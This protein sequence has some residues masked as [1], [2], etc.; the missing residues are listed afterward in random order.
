[1]KVKSTTPWRF[2][3]QSGNLSFRRGIGSDS[4]KGRDTNSQVCWMLWGNDTNKSIWGPFKRIPDVRKFKVELNGHDELFG[5]HG[6]KKRNP[7]KF[8]FE[9]LGNSVLNRYMEHALSRMQN[10]DEKT[11]WRIAD[12]LVQRSNI[13]L[14][15]CLNHVFPN[16][17]RK[18]SM[19]YILAILRSVRKLCKERK[20]FA[21]ISRVYI[22]K[23]KG[24]WRPLGVPKAEWRLYLHMLN[25]I[26]V[27]RYDGIISNNQH[28]FRPGRGTLTAWR[29]ILKRLDAPTIYEYDYKG[30]FDSI[31]Y[32]EVLSWLVEKG[33]PRE[34][35]ILLQQICKSVVK[36]QEE[37]KIPEP[38]RS[39][40][41]DIYGNILPAYLNKPG[42]PP[43]QLHPGKTQEEMITEMR[44]HEIMGEDMATMSDQFVRLNYETVYIKYLE[45]KRAIYLSLIDWEKSQILKQA[46]KA[47]EVGEKLNVETLASYEAG[48]TLLQGKEDTV[49]SKSQLDLLSKVWD[50]KDKGVPQGAA[51]SPFLS[52]MA[53]AMVDSDPSAKPGELMRYADD[54]V[55]FTR[56]TGERDLL[57]LNATE[58]RLGLSY[59]EDKCGFVKKDGVWLKPLKFLGLTYDG[60]TDKLKAST[61]KG[62]ELVFDKQDLVMAVKARE[63]QTAISTSPGD[64]KSTEGSAFSWRE[65]VT[66]SISGFIQSRLYSDSWNA[67]EITQN[68]E[69]TYVRSSWVHSYLARPDKGRERLD[70]FNSS[71]FACYHLARILRKGHITE[72]RGAKDIKEL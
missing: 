69:L 8:R 52:I 21:N 44:N 49:W 26:L 60:T 5:K 10:A 14:I 34:W 15:I 39:I 53:L 2:S 1:M 18:H 6:I 25:Q 71:S 66:S 51:I 36:L 58:K 46:K 57:E 37:D 62:A 20:P 35:N 27:Y 50:W 29:S 32:S 54:F 28:G 31:K 4:P 11:Y 30:F 3:Q 42:A 63:R 13:Y 22:E 64:V 48:K 47:V 17:H 19:A 9:K 38:D 59:N 61:R 56:N 45:Y 16:W 33:L 41:T 23:P 12:H 65:F 24:G 70:V 40:R 43:E 68:F 7:P 55:R 72:R 67:E